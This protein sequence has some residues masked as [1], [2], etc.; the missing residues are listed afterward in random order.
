MQNKWTADRMVDAKGL[1]CPMP[2]VRTKQALQQ[3]E[4]GELLEIQATDRGSVTD[5][6]SWAH[7][8]GHQY[9]G[10]NETDGVL[11]HYVR[12]AENA[13][14]P[15]DIEHPQVISTEEL[16]AKLQADRAV[17]V[18]DV[19]ETLEFAFG[20]IPGAISI[21][22]GVLEARKS[23]L[24]PQKCVYVICRS[25]NRSNAAAK[26]LADQGFEF[27]WN[28]KPGMSGWQGPVNKELEA[29]VPCC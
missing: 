8:A 18:V 15:D 19:R 24:D 23:L 6:R 16:A 17:Q 21:P 9:I 26:W 4:P 10:T 14:D 13:T 5:I 2:I 7:A 11:Y 29:I 1:A 3:A 25:G 22:M 27:V 12:K 28:V 20:H